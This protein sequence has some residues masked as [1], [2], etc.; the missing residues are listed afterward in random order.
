MF[1]QVR[2]SP[3]SLIGSCITTLIP[4]RAAVSI[5]RRWCRTMYCD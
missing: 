2:R 5:T 1:G 4:C 3:V